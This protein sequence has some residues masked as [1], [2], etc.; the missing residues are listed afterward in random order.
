MKHLQANLLYVPLI[1][2]SLFSAVSLADAPMQGT[3]EFS[4]SGAGSS[5]KEFDNNTFAME[6]S[7]GKYL[8]SAAAVGVRQSISVV[9]SQEGDTDWNGA[10]RVFYD[11]HFRQQ[12]MRPFVGAHIGYVYGDSVEE[13]FIAGPEA[14]FKYYVLPSTFVVAQIEYQFLFE[15]ANDANDRYDDGAFA[16][17]V[18][19]GFN[20]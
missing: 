7:Y 13:S 6:A 10:T 3:R 18:G 14:G 1:S 17:S 19:M 16:Y 5:D 12:N 9:D 11:Y 4:V 15:E 20:F 8:S 2:L